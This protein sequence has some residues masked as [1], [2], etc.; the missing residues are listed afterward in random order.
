MIGPPK[1]GPCLGP[2]RRARVA[3]QALKGHR[4][5]PALS[6]INRASGRTRVVLF[7]AVPRAVNR[8]RPIWNP[9]RT[10]FT[11]L[12]RAFPMLRTGVLATFNEGCCDQCCEFVCGMLRVA[13][14]ATSNIR[15]ISSLLPS[16]LRLYCDHVATH[17]C[18][19]HSTSGALS[20]SP[21][22][23]QTQH[24]MSA[25]SQLNICNIKI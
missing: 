22:S 13:G 8:A 10:T 15:S 9:I 18:V 14:R 5:G 17:I 21:S 24:Q 6:T 1:I 19:Q 23:T 12:R 3:A 7:R 4:A 2:A 16:M 25:T 11:M 20:P